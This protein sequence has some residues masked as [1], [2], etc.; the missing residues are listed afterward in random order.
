MMMTIWWSK[1]TR[2]LEFSRS[3]VRRILRIQRPEKRDTFAWRTDRRTDRG[4]GYSSKWM[5]QHILFQ[6]SACC[7]KDCTRKTVCKQIP[8]L[9]RGGNKLDTRETSKQARQAGQAAGNKAWTWTPLGC[10]TSKVTISFEKYTFSMSFV[11]SNSITFKLHYQWRD[12][13][14]LYQVQLRM[15]LQDGTSAVRW[16]KYCRMV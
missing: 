13:A 14:E 12:T 10:Y 4:I 3:W 1:A 16:Y 11:L 15:V 5:L 9:Q 8:Q 2:L 6:L 7:G